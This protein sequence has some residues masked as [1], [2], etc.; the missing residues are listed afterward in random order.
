LNRRGAED[1]EAT[2]ERKRRQNFDAPDSFLFFSVFSASSAPL[3]FSP[4]SK[5]HG[6]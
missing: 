6:G 3:R 2:E 4:V 5:G 1:A